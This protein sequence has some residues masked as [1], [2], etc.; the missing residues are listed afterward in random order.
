MSDFRK[1]HIWKVDWIGN[2]AYDRSG[3]QDHVL[4]NMEPNT[5]PIQSY[6]KKGRLWGAFP[7]D[8]ITRLIKKN[9][10]LYEIL[11]PTFKCKVYFDVD[12]STDSLEDIKKIILDRF[13][14]ARMHISGRKGSWHIVLSNYYADNNLE[15]MRPV[16]QFVME[17]VQHGFDK[18][19]YTLNRNMKCINQRK[20]GKLL[21]EYIEGDT[22]LTK[23]LILH[24]FDDDA[25]NINTI[26]F[27]YEEE[28]MEKRYPPPSTFS[29]F[30]NT[31]GDGKY[32][33]SAHIQ[34]PVMSM[35]NYIDDE[36]NN[37][38]SPA[39]GRTEK[40]IEHTFLIDP[41]GRN[42]TGAVVDNV[43][44]YGIG[45]GRRVL[46][47]TSRITLSNNTMYHLKESGIINYKE[48]TTKG[49]QDGVMDGADFVICS[50]QSLHYLN[51]EFDIVVIDVPETVLNTF[52]DNCTTHG[53]NLG[54]NWA[55]FI[56]LLEAASKVIY[57]DAFTTKLTLSLV[58]GIV[59][60]KHDHAYRHF[61][62]VKTKSD[63]DPWQFVEM[64]TFEDWMTKILHDLGGNF[65]ML[66]KCV[67]T[68]TT[69]SVG[70]NFNQKDVFDR[71]YAHY[72][73][74]ISVR[75]F[76][77]SL[78]RVHHPKST[79]MLLVRTR[80]N[81]YGNEKP[82][83]IRHPD[84]PIYKHLR[85]NIAIE[86]LA[87]NNTTEWQ[88]FSMMCQIANISIRPWELQLAIVANKDYLD[89]LKTGVDL[90]FDWDRI[91][92]LPDHDT[93]K[94]LVYKSYSNCATLDD[95][96]QIEKYMFRRRFPPNNEEYKMDED[97][98]PVVWSKKKDFVDKVHTLVL[99]PKHIINRLFEENGLELNSLL[100][101][102]MKT[103]IP[104]A[105]ILDAFHFNKSIKSYKSG[106]VAQML[107]AFFSM[108]AYGLVKVPSGGDGEKL[109]E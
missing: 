29:Q 38:G 56:M 81:L 34:P 96:L 16:K 15:A 105:Q 66:K 108:R 85:E 109:L 61:E 30:R 101:D 4:A 14:G 51:K 88:T 5:F 24:D 75:D 47:I 59:R 52:S 41:M 55:I 80:F 72:S 22:A 87:Y 103:K 77:Q 53:R 40:G 69:I 45:M 93:F 26:D 102:G 46:W 78:Y 10:G 58:N 35:K 91:A 97:H 49:K 7:P 6:T 63:P 68:N 99:N 21:Q 1:V 48:L 32:L 44:R 54:R 62:I 90:V 89:H 92:D 86:Q 106:L 20:P 18:G 17:N 42:K 50:I 12:K 27:G 60:R 31:I 43:M 25:V 11:H 13:P 94:E 74:M 8:V 82:L 64:E 67:V 71:I 9:Y 28:V 73:N 107:N 23:H 98:L 104:L 3:A 65:A 33:T 2:N 95:R 19:I 76:L 79:E 39:A 84:C 57:M 37:F 83:S 100:P 70:V 36:G